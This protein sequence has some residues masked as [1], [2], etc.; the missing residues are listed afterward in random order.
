MDLSEVRKEVECG[1]WVE[2]F[3][4]TDNNVYSFDSGEKVSGD[5]SVL[6]K[7]LGT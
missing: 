2:M 1:G 3:D 4:K 6:G 5:L 7:T